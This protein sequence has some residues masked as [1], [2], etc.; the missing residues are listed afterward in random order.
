MFT[1]ETR[2]SIS[3]L[4]LET[5]DNG[6]TQ[7]SRFFKSRQVPEQKLICGPLE[8]IQHKQTN[9]KKTKYCDG[10]IIDYAIVWWQFW[11]SSA[12]TVYIYIR[13]GNDRFT[14]FRNIS[15]GIYCLYYVDLLTAYDSRSSMTQCESI[16][17]WSGK[18]IVA[19]NIGVNGLPGLKFDF[20]SFPTVYIMNHHT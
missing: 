19:L 9:V 14:D 7:F 6:E 16:I 2:V 10:Y 11:I 12:C 20:E 1:T 4:P 17:V 18:H 15:V 8:K 3:A 13:L 5:R